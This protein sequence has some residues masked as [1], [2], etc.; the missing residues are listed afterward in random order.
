VRQFEGILVSGFEKEI[1]EFRMDWEFYDQEISS[2]SVQFDH[3]K[4]K[5]DKYVM[6]SNLPNLFVHHRLGVLPDRM[7]LGSIHTPT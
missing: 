4:I 6:K 5:H 3:S 7:S 1:G 2:N